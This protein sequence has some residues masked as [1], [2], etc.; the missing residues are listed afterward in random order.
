M[1]RECTVTHGLGTDDE[2]CSNLFMRG[3]GVWKVKFGHPSLYLS[4]R[5]FCVSQ[6]TGED[7]ARQT[8]AVSVT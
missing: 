6:M 7:M 5:G 1:A 4:R 2:C 8:G 3:R